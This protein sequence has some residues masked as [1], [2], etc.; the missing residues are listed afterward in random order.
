[1][2]MVNGVLFILG[3]IVGITPGYTAMV[4]GSRYQRFLGKTEC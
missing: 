3:K 1:M 2:I 4:D